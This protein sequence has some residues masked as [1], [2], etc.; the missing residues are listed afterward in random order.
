MLKAFMRDR[1]SVNTAALECLATFWPAADM[2]CLSHFLDGVG[3]KAATPH[4]TA[5]LGIL[6]SLFSRSAVAVVAFEA[7]VEGIAPGTSFRPLSVSNT[8]WF[9][10]YEFL[11]QVGSSNSRACR[12]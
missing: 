11:K 6:N 2:P 4:A 1:A 12:W 5:F 8:R 3:D 9:S 7:F 10:W